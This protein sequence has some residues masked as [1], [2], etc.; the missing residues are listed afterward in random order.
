MCNPDRDE[1]PS[2]AEYPR[3]T[4]KPIWWVPRVSSQG[5]NWLGW[6]GDRS[7]LCGTE[8]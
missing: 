8:V 4:Q 1:R 6:E 2:S 3:P 5:I 7:P